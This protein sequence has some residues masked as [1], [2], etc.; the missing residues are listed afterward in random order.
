VD[1]KPQTGEVTVRATNS[2]GTIYP[3]RTELP[4]FF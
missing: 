1:R 4:K 2:G 3:W